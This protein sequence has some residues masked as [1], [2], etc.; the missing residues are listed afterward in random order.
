MPES[1]LV[2]AL[3]MT[4]ATS[5]FKFPTGRPS[6]I[7]STCTAWNMVVA[8]GI[9]LYV[10]LLISSRSIFTRTTRQLDCPQMHPLDARFRCNVLI[11]DPVA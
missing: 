2:L 9:D 8:D 6:K 7:A 10:S 3:L 5:K 4:G 1:V 11:A